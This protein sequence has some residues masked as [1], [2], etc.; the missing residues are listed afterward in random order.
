MHAFVRLLV[1]SQAL[2]RPKERHRCPSH[3]EVLCHRS[4]PAIEVE[5]L[6]KNLRHFLSELMYTE[7]H[8]CTSHLESLWF[9]WYLELLWPFCAP[10]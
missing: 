10:F 9:L 5:V 6:S 2:R 8:R 1:V 3:S 4:L 7:R